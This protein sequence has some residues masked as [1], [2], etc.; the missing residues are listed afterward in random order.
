MC[1]F[2]CKS[3]GLISSDSNKAEVARCFAILLSLSPRR[4]RSPSKDDPIVSRDLLADILRMIVGLPPSP[5]PR[6]PKT[7]PRLNCLCIR[8]QMIEI[9]VHD[10]KLYL[11]RRSTQL[12][13]L[14]ASQHAAIMQQVP[15]AN[16]TV[17]SQR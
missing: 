11:V 5:S 8:G 10:C 13:T 1:K 3:F 15:P 14:A 2:M 17:R 7:A 16:G 9:N 4:H 12:R 6:Q